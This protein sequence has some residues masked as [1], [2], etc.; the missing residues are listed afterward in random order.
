[1]FHSSRHDSLVFPIL[2]HVGKMTHNTMLRLVG[3]MKNRTSI[4]VVRRTYVNDVAFLQ[5]PLVGNLMTN[6]L[7]DRTAIGNQTRG[8][9]PLVVEKLL[10][11]K[12]I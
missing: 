8:F 7:V 5:L 4:R 6:Y 12:P 11:Y 3:N 10:T 9:Q 1:M 2:F